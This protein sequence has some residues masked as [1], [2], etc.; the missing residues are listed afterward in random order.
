LQRH[1]T[2]GVCYYTFDRLSGFGNLAHAI[3]T[4]H[5]GVSPAPFQ[6]LN[7]SRTVGDDVKNVACNIERLHAALGLDVWAMVTA[8]QAQAERVAIVRRDHRGSRIVDVD[9]LLTDEPGIP[10][11][12]RYADCVP[13]LL[14]DP[15]HQA[16][17]VVHAGWRGTVAHI[18]SKAA[19]SMFDEYC[20]QPRDLIACIGPSIGP[21]CYVVQQDVADQVTASFA[22]PDDL[23]IQ[24]DATTYLDLWRANERQLR[25]LGVDQVEV[26][27]LCTADHTSDF[28]SARAGGKTGRFGAIIALV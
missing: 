22:E 4:R 20:T 10:L 8:S 19:R 12:L 26:A 24:R 28:Y 11:M 23:L 16:I 13:I 3:S 6:T 21:C 1:A 25:D 17:G 2:N 15:V 27:E 7:L 14:F 9:A 5:G 18:G